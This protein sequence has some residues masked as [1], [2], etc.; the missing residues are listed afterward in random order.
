MYEELIEKAKSTVAKLHQTASILR[1]LSLGIHPAVV[2]E[3]AN[4]IEELAEA[5]EVVTADP[6]VQPK[7]REVSPY[8]KTFDFG[9]AEL[10]NEDID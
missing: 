3:G 10:D 9:T 6:V 1:G 5:L 2:E 8:Q 7:R 4:T